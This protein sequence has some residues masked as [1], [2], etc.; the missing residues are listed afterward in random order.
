MVRCV[1]HFSADDRIMMVSL[2]ILCTLPLV[3]LGLMV[4]E[5]GGVS[6]PG[7]YVAAVAL[8]ADHPSDC[9]WIPYFIT[10]FGFSSILGK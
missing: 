9:T 8:V 6:F 1:V 4:F 7:E 10:Q 2:A 3:L 5:I